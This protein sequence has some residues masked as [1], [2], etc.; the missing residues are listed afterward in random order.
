MVRLVLEGISTHKGRCFQ[1]GYVVYPRQGVAF[2]DEE[3]RLYVGHPDC[4]FVE[5]KNRADGTVEIGAHVSE[6][7]IS[8]LERKY[9]VDG[10]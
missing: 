3:G 6:L 7:H 8:R 2:R 1:C 4:C 9:A 10:A 5:L